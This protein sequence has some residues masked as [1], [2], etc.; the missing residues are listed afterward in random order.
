MSGFL[1]GGPLGPYFELFLQIIIKF[2]YIYLI[3]L[4][5]LFYFQLEL[6]AINPNKKVV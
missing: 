6:Y 1:F 2:Y 3:F 4:N 5:I